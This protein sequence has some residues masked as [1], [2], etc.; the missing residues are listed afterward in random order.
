MMT[1]IKNK[2]LNVMYEL[3]EK[4]KNFE[5]EAGQNYSDWDSLE[6][7]LNEKDK[8]KFSWIKLSVV[9]L[10]LCIPIGLHDLAVNSDSQQHSTRISAN[11][12]SEILPSKKKKQHYCMNL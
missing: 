8:K 9:F 12:Q 5:T 11:S 2:D 4:L 10:V 6:K 1:L 7:A 3:F